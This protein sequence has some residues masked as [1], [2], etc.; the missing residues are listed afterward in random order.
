MHRFRLS[1]R[2]QVDFDEIIDYLRKVAGPTVA[3]KYGRN[4]QNAVNRVAE[5]PGIGSPRPQF[6]PGTRVTI[7]RPYLIFYEEAEGSGEVLV[8]RVLHE[9]RNITRDLLRSR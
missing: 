6:G 7:V 3:N 4:I 8:L 2:A 5:I 1:A 9:R